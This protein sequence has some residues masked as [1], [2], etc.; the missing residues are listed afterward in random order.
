VRRRGIAS[1]WTATGPGLGWPARAALEQARSGYDLARQLF[2]QN[3]TVEALAA[4]DQATPLFRTLARDRP[5]YLPALGAALNLNGMILGEL[6]RYGESLA[7]LA[8]ASDIHREPAA[9]DRATFLGRYLASRYR[10]GTVLAAA[11]RAHEAAQA[12]VE[13][14]AGVREL[15]VRDGLGPYFDLLFGCL[16]QIGVDLAEGGRLPESLPYLREALDVCR[17]LPAPDRERSFAL[18]NYA[19]VLAR[20]GDRDALPVVAAAV[21]AIPRLSGD[22]YP[23]ATAYWTD[24]FVRLTF[25]ADLPAALAS[26]GLAVA[27]FRELAAADPVTHGADLRK[28]IGTEA[29]IRAALSR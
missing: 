11:D 2:A 6:G 18:T 26:A 14:V 9:T 28:A 8:E 20:L 1:W 5:S 22:A 19:E 3:R 16:T 21:A 24:A 17:A 25:G 10:Y 29:D 23:V 7:I 13:V 27:G 12:Y 4:M 15:A